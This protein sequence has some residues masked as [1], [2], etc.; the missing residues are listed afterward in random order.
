M[1]FTELAEKRYSVRK[2]EPKP[3]SEEDLKKILHAGHVAPTGCNNQ[4]QRVLVINSPEAIEKLKECTKCHF[5][6]QTAL[7]VGYKKDEVWVRPYDGANCGWTDA[8]I[9][10][11]HMMLQAEELGVGSCLVMHF[12]PVKMRTAFEVP[13][14][15]EMVVLL[16]LGYPAADA[17]ANPR[18][19]Q[20]RPEEEVIFYNQF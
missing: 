18:H 9:V 14:D 1:N 8:A 11:T 12:D 4:P 7:L 15:I 20:F 5:D 13:E 16:V 6:T 19:S 2:F 17:E 10:T 3:V